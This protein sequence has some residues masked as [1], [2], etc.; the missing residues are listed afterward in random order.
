MDFKCPVNHTGSPQDLL[1]ERIEQKCDSLCLQHFCW[2]TSKKSVVVSL[3]FAELP[4]EHIKEK[5]D[6]L[7]LSAALLLEHIKEK[8]AAEMTDSPPII[9]EALQSYFASRIDELS[10]MRLSIVNESNKN[11]EQ[12][13]EL[14]L[15]LSAVEERDQ[16]LKEQ[17]QQLTKERT[18]FEEECKVERAELARQWQQLRDEIT[19]M[20]E[21]N[22]IQKVGRF[23][24]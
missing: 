3:F 20:E 9:T 12:L 23:L 21:M 15:R 10:S 13:A 8:C 16:Q 19:R 24:D 5:C 2:S 6:C 22:N 7:S 14:K 17:E 1:L 11:E 18:G 4:L